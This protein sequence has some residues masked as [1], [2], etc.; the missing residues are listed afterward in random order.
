MP[1]SVEDLADRVRHGLFPG[2]RQSGRSELLERVGWRE[3]WKENQGL[4]ARDVAAW[5]GTCYI[6]VAR[7][8]VEQSG[9]SSGS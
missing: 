2:C 5:R 6:K 1:R 9:S 4:A 8:G 7:C 3:G